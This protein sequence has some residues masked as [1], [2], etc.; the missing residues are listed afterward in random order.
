MASKRNR[1]D[2]PNLP[3]WA[4]TLWEQLNKPDIISFADVADGPLIERRHGLRRDDLVEIEL[5]ARAYPDDTDL[6]VHGR[7]MSSGKTMVELM[8]ENGEM[9]YV[10][11]DVIVRLR[12]IA[13]MRPPYI[14]DD[15][16]LTFEREDQKRRSK[17][18]EKVEREAQGTDDGHIWG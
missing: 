2:D 15:E 18:H 4:R 10:A 9:Q 12:L 13:H 3:D 6:L 17:L 5:D 14:D 16:L 7:L 8:D 1:K 11:K